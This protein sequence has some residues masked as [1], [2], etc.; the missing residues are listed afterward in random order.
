MAGLFKSPCARHIE[1]L[2]FEGDSGQHPVEGT[3]SVGGDEYHTIPKIVSI[4]GF[5]NQLLTLRKIRL[6]EAVSELLS[7]PIRLALWGVYG[8]LHFYCLRK[9]K[10]LYEMALLRQ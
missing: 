9:V 3:L 1:D 8:V 10:S 6:N 2:S 5:A 7:Y 4:P